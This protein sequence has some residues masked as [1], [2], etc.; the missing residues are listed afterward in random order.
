M[1]ERAGLS[2][3]CGSEVRTVIGDAVEICSKADASNRWDQ[4]LSPTPSHLFD[5]NRDH[6]YPFELPC[7]EKRDA[8]SLRR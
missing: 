1:D 6:D 4:E 2:V 8:Q 7:F 5:L 3:C